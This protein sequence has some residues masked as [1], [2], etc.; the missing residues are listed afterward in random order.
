MLTTPKEFVERFRAV[1]AARG[2]RGVSTP[3]DLIGGWEQLV[4]VVAEGYDDNIYEYRNDLSVRERIEVLLQDESLSGVEQMERVRTQVGEIDARFRSLLRP[5]PVRGNSPWW[6]AHL[7]AYAG[8][9]LVADIKA[10]YGVSIE[11]RQ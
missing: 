1:V 7:P 9:E 6:E 4:D 2:W 3:F 11:E 5:E 10:A 8:A